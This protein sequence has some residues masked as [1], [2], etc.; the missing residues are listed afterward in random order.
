MKINI[1][2]LHKIDELF[3]NDIKIEIRAYFYNKVIEVVKGKYE[4]VNCAKTYFVIYDKNNIKVMEEKDF[5]NLLK[6]AL[7]NQTIL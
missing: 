4:N 5:A 1:N 6:K 2:N 7:K 3:I